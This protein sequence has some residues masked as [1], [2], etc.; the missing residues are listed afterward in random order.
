MQEMEELEE[1]VVGE[2]AETDLV[3]RSLPDM[4]EMVILG[5]VVVQ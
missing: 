1:P 2:E 3:V 4:V 5:A